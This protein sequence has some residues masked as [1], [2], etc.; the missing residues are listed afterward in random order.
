MKTITLEVS[1]TAAEKIERMSPIEKN[2][3]SETLMQLVVNRRSL[4]EIMDDISSQAERNGLT[5][6]VFEKILKEID[7][8]RK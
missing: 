5:P 3:V 8:E 6:E 2:A 1:D 4:E 7:E